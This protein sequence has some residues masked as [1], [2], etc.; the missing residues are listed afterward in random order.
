MA[1]LAQ[2]KQAIE[3]EGYLMARDWC[4]KYSTK[5]APFIREDVDRWIHQ[6]WLP[7]KKFFNR[8]RALKADMPVPPEVKE[9][10]RAREIQRV[11]NEEAVREGKTQVFNCRAKRTNKH[12]S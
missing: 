10:C 7:Y 5:D 8:Y 11:A 9:Y 2:M 6:G 1:T 12:E 3:A 4:E